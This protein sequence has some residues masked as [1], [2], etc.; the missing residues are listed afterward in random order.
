MAKRLLFLSNDHSGS[1][2]L[3]FSVMVFL[4]GCIGFGFFSVAPKA[5]KQNGT[6]VIATKT[7][8][9]RGFSTLLP[10]NLT[11][12]QHE[13]LSF[14]YSVAKSDGYKNPEYLQGLILQESAAGG[15][16][17]FRVAGDPVKKENQYFGVGQIKLAAAI[18]VLKNF[19][20]MWGFLQT[21]THEELQAKLI[22]DDYF[23]IRIASKYLLLMGVNKS[24]NFAL[25][26]YNRG[27]G[28]A[29]NIINHDEFEYTRGVINYAAS[30]AVKQVNKKQ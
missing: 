20:E 11:A 22:L 26:A 28:G 15:S 14:A 18:D 6:A 25:T 23:N 12:K 5:L 10:N 1:L 13:L 27:L 9:G 16:S 29:Q 24:A 2:K 4:L 8:N 19:P 3:N 21:R 30:A 17:N 7:N